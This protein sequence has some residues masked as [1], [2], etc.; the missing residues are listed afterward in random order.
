MAWT[1]PKTYTEDRRHRAAELNTYERDNMLALYQARRWNL[2]RLDLVP[3]TDYTLTV[4]DGPRVLLIVAAATT[5]RLLGASGRA[6]WRV[7]AIIVSGASACTLAR[8]GSDTI[9]SLAADLV[10]TGSIKS[11]LMISDGV[12][13]WSIEGSA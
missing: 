10:F 7:M 1:T 4:A 5:I 11:R 9:D 12:S 2:R 6:G 13:D 8:N 3:T